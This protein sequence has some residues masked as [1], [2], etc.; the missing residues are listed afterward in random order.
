MHTIPFG[1]GFQ[2]FWVISS[3][4]NLMKAIDLIPDT[5]TD[6][7]MHAR[8]VPHSWGLCLCL[9]SLKAGGGPCVSDLLMESLWDK[10]ERKGRKQDE[11]GEE[12][13]QRNGFC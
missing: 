9:D 1:R 12:R 10:L 8:L 2:P 11:A 5:D 13:K 3:L 4:E 6:M 7:R